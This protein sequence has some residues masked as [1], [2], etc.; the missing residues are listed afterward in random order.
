MDAGASAASDTRRRYRDPPR[1]TSSSSRRPGW[2]CDHQ[3]DQ[4]RD[5]DPGDAATA[6]RASR[7]VAG[8]P[9]RRPGRYRRTPIR[10]ARSA[11]A[12]PRRPGRP[13]WRHGVLRRLIPDCRVGVGDS[14]RHGR[15]TVKLFLELLGVFLGQRGLPT[16]PPY[17][18]SAAT[19]LSGVIFSTIMNQHDVPGWAP[20]PDLILKLRVDRLLPH[21]PEEGPEATPGFRSP[22]RRDEG[23]QAER[24]A[25]R[26]ICHVA[27][28]P[29]DG[30]QV[31]WV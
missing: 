13:A 5:L 24:R 11:N 4:H 16:V 9:R 10:P 2:I 27:P 7:G 20:V 22:G 28:C 8:A 14:G 1:T 19:A 23:P 26:N 25:P 29:V 12:T 6:D 18:L 15:R 17:L 30:I 21:V 31:V 3:H